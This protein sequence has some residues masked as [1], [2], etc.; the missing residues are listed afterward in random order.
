M[1]MIILP[2]CIKRML[3]PWMNL[4]AILTM[5]T[6]LTSIIGA[7]QTR[8]RLRGVEFTGESSKGAGGERSEYGTRL[9]PADPTVPFCP[10]PEA[11]TPKA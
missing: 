5:A 4:Y 2:Q 8:Q 1:W 3:P 7:T 10:E 9:R 6:V 11:S